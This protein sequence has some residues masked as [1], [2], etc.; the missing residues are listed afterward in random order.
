MDRLKAAWDWLQCSRW[1][2]V[3]AYSIVAVVCFT[4]LLAGIQ[5]TSIPQDLTEIDGVTIKGVPWL[6][7]NRMFWH[8]T[9]A[10][11]LAALLT[12]ILDL[13][14][15]GEVIRRY[16]KQGSLIPTESIEAYTN[17]YSDFTKHLSYSRNRLSQHQR[18]STKH[19]VQHVMNEI[20]ELRRAQLNLLS[21]CG[22]NMRRVLEQQGTSWLDNVDSFAANVDEIEQSISA[23]SVEDIGQ[24]QAGARDS[25]VDTP[26]CP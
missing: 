1:G 12:L 11:G 9:L 13:W 21:V 5:A 8:V 7:T 4:V 14:F 15:R 24:V 22:P 3:V 23:A 10:L 20:T 16:R 17:A 19:P 6:L 18:D 25:E 2:L 26:G